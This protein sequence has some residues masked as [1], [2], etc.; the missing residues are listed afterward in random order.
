MGTDDSGWQP[1]PEKPRRPNRVVAL[2]VLAF[3]ALL[4]FL[5]LL[6]VLF[7]YDDPIGGGLTTAFGQDVWTAILLVV[8]LAILVVQIILLGGGRSRTWSTADG[9]AMMAEPVWEESVEMANPSA[10]APAA[11]WTAAP[12]EP[13]PEVQ[14][15]CTGCGTIFEKIYTDIDEEHERVFAC[16]NCGRQGF[17]KTYEVKQAP[18]RNVVCHTCGREYRKYRETA[19]CRHCHTPA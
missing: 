17:L 11:T 12:V 15:G 4:P 8:L 19:E 14:I 5:L 18:I 16:P 7:N 9:E 3:A 6:D 1:A 2:I 10:V 13:A